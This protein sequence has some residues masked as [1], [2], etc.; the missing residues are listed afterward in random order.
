[1]C[2]AE[3]AGGSGHLEQRLRGDG[4]RQEA[5]EGRR[6]ELARGCEHVGS[7]LAPHDGADCEHPPAVL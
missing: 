2:D 4:L 3:A 5:E 6:I 1:V 7:E